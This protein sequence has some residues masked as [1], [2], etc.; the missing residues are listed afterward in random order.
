[1]EHR[2]KENIET[3]LGCIIPIA[4]I[5]SIIYFW[6]EICDIFEVCQEFVKQHLLL[7][8]GIGFGLWLLIVC[9][10]G[11]VEYI[12]DRIKTNKAKKFTLDVFAKYP[13]AFVVFLKERKEERI[14]DFSKW[15]FRNAADKGI[16]W[17]I[18][19][20]EE[21]ETRKRI[22]AERNSLKSK[23]P[24][25]YKCWTEEHK[26]DKLIDIEH[27]DEIGEYERIYSLGNHIPS[28]ICDLENLVHIHF[29]II[30][31][32]NKIYR[33]YDKMVPVSFKYRMLECIKEDYKCRYEE[34]ENEA[35]CDIYSLFFFQPNNIP[36]L[37]DKE[38]EEKILGI[39]GCYCE[40]LGEDVLVIYDSQESINSNLISCWNHLIDALHSSAKCS[41]VDVCS[42][43]DKLERMDNRQLIICLNCQSS[44][45]KQSDFSSIIYNKYAYKCPVLM[46]I[47]LVAEL[48]PLEEKIVRLT[49]YSH[50]LKNES[51]EIKKYL[52]EN[53]VKE[54]YHFTS[55]NNVESIIKNGGLYSWYSAPN[56]GVSITNPGGGSRSR[57]QD[58]AHGVQ[59]YVHLSFC[60]SHP[61]KHKLEESLIYS[62]Q[63]RID[64]IVCEF[65]KTLFS[66]LNAADNNCRFGNDMNALKR[67]DFEAVRTSYLRKTDPKFKKH[68]AEVMV[69][70]FIPLKYITNL[71]QIKWQLE[72]Y[73]KH[74]EDIINEMRRKIDPLYGLM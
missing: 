4:V 74:K 33:V 67:V 59:D 40:N 58:I 22:E 24:N 5:G 30:N 19:T 29:N 41:L 56:N 60:H 9:I 13:L 42:M 16:N 1:M 55:I 28:F 36:S 7:L 12:Q 2:T 15:D 53:N 38:L 47:S 48:T 10:I 35:K 54:L 45:E 49:E 46:H 18:K 27:K 21:E 52:E 70:K 11:L 50:Q 61:M 44:T 62:V 64:P 26:Y 34:K 23:Y 17:W 69:P 20:Q 6:D 65:E 31:I 8:I 25:G 73:K 14:E 51:S 32:L 43:D 63:L 71:D 66:D 68:Q 3:T 37:I 72:Y 57:T 39:I